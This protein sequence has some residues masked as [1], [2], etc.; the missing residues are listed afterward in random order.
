M[1]NDST[2]TRTPDG[3]IRTRGAGHLGFHRRDGFHAGIVAGCKVI[4]AGR[5]LRAAVPRN[6][7][8]EYPSSVRGH[9]L[10]LEI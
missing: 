4:A 3:A 2:Q 10:D 1:R 5:L 7:F 9:L 6:G 8:S